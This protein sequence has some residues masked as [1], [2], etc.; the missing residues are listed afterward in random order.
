MT[1][2]K[3]YFPRYW[4]LVRGIHRS[5]VNSPHKGPV[6]R[7]FDVSLI[8]ARANNET[9]RRVAGDLRRYDIHYDVVM[10]CIKAMLANDEHL[11][12]MPSLKHLYLISV[13]S[14]GVL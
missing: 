12:L 5:P 10:I 1:S 4:P 13:M 14:F 2:S 8:L 6:T 3:K 11:I 9:N 7:S